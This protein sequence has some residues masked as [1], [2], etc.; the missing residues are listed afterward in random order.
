MKK[1]VL[2]TALLVSMS[3]SGVVSTTYKHLNE[4][5]YTDTQISSHLSEFRYLSTSEQQMIAPLQT[6]GVPLKDV[7]SIIEKKRTAEKKASK[8]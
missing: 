1:I 4:Q 2:T 5:G 6:A 8:K 7:L 3:F